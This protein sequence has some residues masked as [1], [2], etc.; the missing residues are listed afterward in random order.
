MVE[1]L[2]LATP[3]GIRTCNLA[4]ESFLVKELCDSAQPPSSKCGRIQLAANVFISNWVGFLYRKALLSKVAQRGWDADPVPTKRKM[5][6]QCPVV[7]RGESLRK[8]PQI[9]GIGR[10]HHLPGRIANQ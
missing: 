9:W 1:V 4:S 8:N 3:P 5:I 7:R 10:Q 6:D 2:S